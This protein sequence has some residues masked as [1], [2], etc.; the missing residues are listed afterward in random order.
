MFYLV[1][2]PLTYMKKVDTEEIN[3]YKE[4]IIQEQGENSVS[5]TYPEISIVKY[6]NNKINNPEENDTEIVENV[7]NTIVETT[8][9]ENNN[10][11]VYLLFGNFL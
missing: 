9:N 4:V 2:R 7:D 8:E 6:I 3:N 11:I 10:K 1:S 5:T